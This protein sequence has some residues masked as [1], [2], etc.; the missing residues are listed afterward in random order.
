MN[1]TTPKNPRDISGYL[2]R[3]PTVPIR[4]DV[5]DTGKRGESV[6]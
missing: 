2:C 4:K 3:G 6:C 1:Q 5:S